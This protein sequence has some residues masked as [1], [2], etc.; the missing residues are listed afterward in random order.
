MVGIDSELDAAEERAVI[1][2]FDDTQPAVSLG[3]DG[4]RSGGYD[5]SNIGAHEYL[6]RAAARGSVGGEVLNAAGI[7]RLSGHDKAG[8]R[9]VRGSGEHEGII[10]RAGIARY[11]NAVRKLG[12]IEGITAVDVGEPY[13][14][15]TGEGITAPG[16]LEG[17]G[18][19][20][21]GVGKRVP[22]PCVL[23]ELI[24]PG[25]HVLITG[26]RADPIGMRCAVREGITAGFALL[27]E[28]EADRVRSSLTGL[29]GSEA[30]GEHTG[31]AVLEDRFKTFEGSG[32][33]QRGGRCLLVGTAV[34]AVGRVLY[35]VDVLTCLDDPVAGSI[36]ILPLAVVVVL[37][38]VECGV[39]L[40]L[41]GDGT[42]TVG[43]DGAGFCERAHGDEGNAEKRREQQRDETCRFLHTFLLDLFSFLFVG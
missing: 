31:I 24:S 42:F 3:V 20:R 5:L 25:K 18:V 28:P 41:D 30:V 32:A 38:I 10:A 22:V 43:V 6:L 33:E 21:D 34:G 40:R 26:L 4:N 37:E 39:I 23:E 16:E 7:A 27:T 15:L 12:G 11:G 8:T 19:E 1:A 29:V 2:L 35:A 17:S 9:G 36:Q 14:G 13:A